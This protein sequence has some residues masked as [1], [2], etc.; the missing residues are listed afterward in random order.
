MAAELEAA[1]TLL[2][3][4]AAT[5][6]ALRSRLRTSQALVW[7][8]QAL[9]LTRMAPSGTSHKPVSA[10][11]DLRFK[12]RMEWEVS[13]RIA[14]VDR[15]LR[16][17]PP[18][19]RFWHRKKKV[20]LEQ[21]ARAKIQVEAAASKERRAKMAK[22]GPTAQPKKVIRAKKTTPPLRIQTNISIESSPAQSP[23]A[24]KR[25]R[26]QTDE[27]ISAIHKPTIAGMD[28]PQESKTTGAKMLIPSDSP[29]LSPMKISKENQQPNEIKT[30]AVAV[31]DESSAKDVVSDKNS[32]TL[33]DSKRESTMPETENA[34]EQAALELKLE[35]DTS[36]LEIQ[37]QQFSQKREGN[38]AISPPS[39]SKE[40]SPSGHT[41]TSQRRQQPWQNPSVSSLGR[42]VLSEFRSSGGPS[43]G[44]PPISVSARGQ[45]RQL[46][47]DV[48]RRLFSDLDSDKDGRLNRIETCLALHRLQIVVPAAK[49]ATFFRHIYDSSQSHD[50]FVEPWK[51]VI[52]YAQFVA[53]VTAVHEKQQQ[54]R[55]PKLNTRQRAARIARSPPQP[56]V[57][58]RGHRVRQYVVESD[59]DEEHTANAVFEKI[60]DYLVGRLLS[61]PTK[62][63]VKATT[64][65]VR[66]S[67][68]NVLPGKKIQDEV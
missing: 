40:S 64:A 67:L 58:P 55:R 19:Q 38:I 45:P 8:D 65:V 1:Y 2:T 12:R 3:Q 15:E 21:T 68:E 27:L 36:P 52:S 51:E 42:Q 66:R 47:R 4:A 57:S 48:L 54:F 46:N 26:K 60:P 61:E 56:E 62:S 44:L 43:F 22:E 37:L 30:V 32:E 24:S 16:D 13:R 63:S 9:M 39:S 6:H 31:E 33:T 10:P 29:V 7:G 50:D 18:N 49:I 35:Q 59:L 28:T 20:E 41:T 14:R 25:S 34:S 11:V 53:F 17:L 23:L 5:D